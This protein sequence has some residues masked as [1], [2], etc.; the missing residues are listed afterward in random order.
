MS[1]IRDQKRLVPCLFCWSQNLL[2]NLIMLHL[3]QQVP[4]LIRIR[5]THLGD[6]F[7]LDAKQTTS[8]YIDWIRDLKDVDATALWCWTV[9]KAL[10]PLEE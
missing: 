10:Y 3:A 6:R 5:T 1:P 7:D 2:G 4:I 8:L 9:L